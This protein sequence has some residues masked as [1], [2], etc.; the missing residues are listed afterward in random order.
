[1]AI[2]GKIIGGA[3]G[4]ALGGPFGALM[5]AA[6]GHMVDRMTAGTRAKPRPEDFDRSARQVAF[7]VALIVLGAKMAK[8]DGVVSRHEVEAFKR[9]FRIPPADQS[10]VAKVFDQAKQEA[11]GFEPYAE[12]VAQLFA[13]N[14]AVLEGLLDGLF[15]IALADGVMHQA[16]TAYL[17][18]VADIFGFDEHKFERIHAGHMGPGHADPYD[19]LGVPHDAPEQEIKTAYRQLIRE[20]HPDTLI[21]QGMPQDFI[22]LANEKMAAINDAHDRILKQRDLK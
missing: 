19:I 20:N 8:A 6:A 22:D 5:G 16:E 3:A 18:R 7:T 1:M 15:H 4:F 10:D 12:Q 11:A 14:P 9:V 2:W 17:R 21:A 13:H